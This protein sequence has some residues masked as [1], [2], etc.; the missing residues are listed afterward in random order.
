M[1]GIVDFIT[2]PNLDTPVPV[3]GQLVKTLGQL[4]EGINPLPSRINDLG[5]IKESG[6]LGTKLFLDRRNYEIRLV[7]STPRL[8]E[9]PDGL[10]PSRS[11]IHMESVRITEK[12]HM[13]P[14]DHRNVRALNTSGGFES[15]NTWLKQNLWSSV[16][17]VRATLEWHAL[18][19]LRGEILD[20]DGSVIDDLYSVTG[21]TRP[22]TIEFNLETASTDVIG[23]FRQARRVSAK[24]L[25]GAPVTRWHAFAGDNYFDKLISHKS[26]K[27]TWLNTKRSREGRDTGSYES[28]DVAGVTV[29]NYNGYIGDRDFVGPDEIR[30]FPVGSPGLYQRHYAPG[31]RFPFNDGL[32]LR[33][34][35]MPYRKDDG[36]GI[37][38]IVQSNPI[39]L[40][41]R[42]AAL[43]AGVS[44]TEATTPLPDWSTILGG[45]GGGEG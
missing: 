20:A 14:D 43:L 23:K 1:T 38:F 41:T 42:P 8:S 30:I 6:M 34:Y 3:D 39:T 19:M 24:G 21:M 15:V 31:D 25:Q 33:E 17:S 9:V 45:N 32:G 18:G 2:Q 35:V 12:F 7:Q 13:S 28:I 40:C 16:N 26:M 44:D 10:A 36:T 5:L 27:E 22:A 4:V 37:L 11:N 29:E